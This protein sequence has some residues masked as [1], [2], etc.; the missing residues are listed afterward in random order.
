MA[1]SPVA[2]GPG[3]KY[4]R[5]ARAKGLREAVI[6]YKHALKNAMIPIVTVIGLNFAYLLGGTVLIEH[7]FALPGIGRLVLQSIY[8]RDYPVVQGV[9]LI[10]AVVFIVMNLIVD[11][12]YRF[13]NPKIRYQ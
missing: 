12:I 6:T 4:I 8:N 2:E 11:L 13:L 5:T 9:I 10:V 1:R 3:E 7:I